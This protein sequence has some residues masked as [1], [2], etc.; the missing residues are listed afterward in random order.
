MVFDFSDINLVA[1]VVAALVPFVI[2]GL[3]Y[4]PLFLKAW[5]KETGISEKE[6]RGDSVRTFGLS[7]VAN[8]VMMYVLA[9]LFSKAGELTATEG[10]KAGLL[11]GIAF[12]AMMLATQYL[13]AKRSLKLWVIDASYNVLSTA[14]AGAVLGALL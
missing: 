8:L 7:I 4:G 6:M 3:W 10:L 5:Q 13:F 11:I 12:Q 9:G 2:G 1:V 14:L